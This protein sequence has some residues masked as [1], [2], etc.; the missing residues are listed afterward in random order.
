MTANPRRENRAVT[1]TPN[2]PSR[3]EPVP[4]QLTRMEGTIN[5]IAYQ[6]SEVQGDIK[7]IRGDGA[8]LTGRIGAVERAQAQS[9]GASGTWKTWLPTILTALALLAA[10]GFGVKFGG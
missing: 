2:E 10:L 1:T 8:G 3:L 4:V 9:S 7:E 6:F 5:L